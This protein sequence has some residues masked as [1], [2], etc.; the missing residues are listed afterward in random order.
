MF[1]VYI[2]KRLLSVDVLFEMLL[3]GFGVGR[4][5]GTGTVKSDQMDYRFVYIVSSL[6]AER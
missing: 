4:F 5:N 2:P 3:Q 6:A 1:V